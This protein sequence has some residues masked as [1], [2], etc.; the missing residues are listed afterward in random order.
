MAL[1]FGI[2]RSFTSGNKIHCNKTKWRFLLFYKLIE[3]IGL[4]FTD[5]FINDWIEQL[6]T[7]FSLFMLL[8][9]HIFYS[10]MDVKLDS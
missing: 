5:N 1:L 10:G 2:F 4:L 8:M 9:L 6:F 3:F 7:F